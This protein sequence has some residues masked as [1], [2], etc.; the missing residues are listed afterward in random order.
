MKAK[1]RR[2]GQGALEEL[3]FTL[4][5][6]LPRL[7]LTRLLGWFSRIE[8]P[9]VVRPAIAV[10]RRFGGLEL[11]D[12]PR[13]RFRSV[14]DCFT[15]E[16][17]PGARPIDPTPGVLLSPC[18]GGVVACGALEGLEAIQVKGLSYSIGELLGDEALAGQFR[19]G[20]YVAVRLSAGMYHRFHAPADATLRRVRH[21]RGDTWNVNPPALARVPRLYCRNERMVIELS[22]RHPAG[23]TLLL[24]PVAAVGVAGIRIR[25]I[26]GRFGLDYAGPAVHECASYRR[27][28][29]ELGHFEQGSTIVVLAPPGFTRLVSL[30]DRL[31]A[32]QRL[33]GLPA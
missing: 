12:C 2:P 27:R 32:G 22:L 1:P 8:H 15:R 18:D 11:E 20:T 28:G 26:A 23:T 25:G 6:R 3:N 4:T 24:V 19:G 16:L 7:A 14:H 10:W 17:R 33:L 9:L 21:I 29:E 13:R 30:G 5:N 31:R